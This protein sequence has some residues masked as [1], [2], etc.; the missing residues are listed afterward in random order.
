M[1][2]FL[3]SRVVW[4]SVPDWITALGAFMIGTVAAVIGVV[5]FR[6]SGYQPDV[7]AWVDKSHRHIAVRVTNTGRMAGFVSA[8]NVPRQGSLVY[9]VTYPG[10]TPNSGW[11]TVRVPAF[12]VALIYLALLNPNDRF[13][14]RPTVDVWLGAKLCRKAQCDVD[15]SYN[16]DALLAQVPTATTHDGG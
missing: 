10:L 9:D 2:E 15:P 4:G 12:D 7:D 14:A 13:E 16:Y 1:T 8:I 11:A 5:Q 3:L 6:L